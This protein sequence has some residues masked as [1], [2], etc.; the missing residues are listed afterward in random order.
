[1]QEFLEGIIIGIVGMGVASWIIIE[2]M[3]RMWD[4]DRRWFNSRLDWWASEHRE[5]IRKIK[6]H[7]NETDSADWWKES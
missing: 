4:A 3:Q 1:M 2:A 7:E 5:L 6:E